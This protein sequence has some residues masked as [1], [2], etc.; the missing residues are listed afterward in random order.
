[1]NYQDPYGLNPPD[2]PI[3]DKIIKVYQADDTIVY[4]TA[5]DPFTQ[6]PCRPADC[7]LEFTIVNRRFNTDILFK[8]DWVKGIVPKD[9]GV[10]QITIPTRNTLFERGSLLYSLTWYNILRS[11]RKVLEEGGFL[12]E[13]SA[14]A[15]NPQVPYNVGDRCRKEQSYGF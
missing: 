3:S 10:V 13:Y 12:I 1:M 8:A 14:D 4:R 5:L 11:E 2:A 9:N 6:L 15:P 7:H